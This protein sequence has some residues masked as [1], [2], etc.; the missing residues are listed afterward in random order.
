M[1][2]L[3]A[4][5]SPTEA[6]LQAEINRFETAARQ[7]MQGDIH[8][9]V[10]KRFRL[11]QGIYG[12]RQADVQMVR[13]KIPLGDLTSEQ[14]R[15]IARLSE[16]YATGTS[17]V[18]TRQDIQLHFVRLDQIGPLLR[19]L[20]AVGLTT[21]EACGNTVRNV[22]LCPLAGICPDEL[23]DITPYAM[24]T[25]QFFLR[26]PICEDLPRK[27]KFAFSGCAHDR[28]MTGIHD[29]GVMAVSLGRG[30]NA[31]RKA[32]LS[33]NSISAQASTDDA[34]NGSEALGFRI[35]VGGGLGP[36]PRRPYLL[37]EFVN[38]NDLLPTC[39]AV[40]RVFS[41]LGNRKNRSL[42]R[43][44]FLIEKIGFEPFYRMYHEE[45]T[46][47]RQGRPLLLPEALR[48]I[49]PRI[50]AASLTLNAAGATASLNAAPGFD[51]WRRH[52][53]IAQ[54]QPGLHA[55]QIRLIIGDI[56]AP[57]LY[58]IAELADRFAHGRVRTTQHQNLLFRNVPA[59]SLPALHAALA[60]QGLAHTGAED[61][62]D[63]ISCPGTET[64]GLGITASKGLGRVL[65]E[66][67]RLNGETDPEIRNIAIKISGCPNSCAQHHIATIG[68]HGLAEKFDGRLL[69]A[70]QLHLGGRLTP[71][72]VQFGLMFPLK[73]PAKR[74]PDVVQRLLSLYR[75][76]R[77]PGESFLAYVDRTGKA[78][79][80]QELAPL[81]K[82]AGTEADA[83]LFQD[84]GDTTD[85]TME[86]HGAGECGS[87][88]VNFVAQHFE[89]SAYELEHAQVFLLKERPFDASTRADLA[90]IA[91]VKA[92]L[93][94]EE[95]EPVS[96]EEALR[97]FE[98]R[99]IAN[100]YL[101]EPIWSTVTELRCR[102]L[103]TPLTLP[104]AQHY[105]AAVLKLVDACR[106]HY[107]QVTGGPLAVQAPVAQP[108]T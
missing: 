86:D 23:F 97:E 56:A 3:T 59:A 85:Y 50:R 75:T 26:N 33:G 49:P 21:R 54:R 69:P 61:L 84:W 71:Q 73:F 107:E 96:H 93:T 77:Q 87:A 29:I 102:Q 70:Y 8:P 106:A 65:T 52:N 39:E 104:E 67:L 90:L 34:T 60:E 63:V 108:H 18:T 11:K 98:A 1:N 45:L 28:A 5:P 78:R 91:A 95:I 42:A 66:Q 89:D 4:I 20:A 82:P 43:I 32:E 72:S 68:F 103:V 47:I 19:E 30:G 57:A 55:V 10:F 76:E 81:A 16:Q 92:L 88:A 51:A 48:T 94:M 62:G 79:F 27:F 64:C 17:H 31:D 15:T 12:Q 58:V 46:R 105:V 7:F 13:I 6:E 35:T 74:V 40:L 41:R 37:E 2:Q 36:S 22:T 44:K 99:I 38:P 14:T 25:A 80:Q 53:V 9:D 100:G 101:P 83:E 24:A